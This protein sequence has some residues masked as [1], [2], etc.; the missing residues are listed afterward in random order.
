MDL[1]GRDLILGVDL[2]QSDCHISYYDVSRQDTVTVTDTSGSPFFPN[3]IFWE[4]DTRKWYSGGEAL[5]IKSKNQ[6]M[7]IEPLKGRPGS[8]ISIGEE[9][10]SEK[11]LLYMM[12]RLNVE[13]AMNQLKTTDILSICITTDIEH[14]LVPEFETDLAAELGISK[15]KVRLVHRANSYLPYILKD[16]VD[17]RYP[18]GIFNFSK[19]G[20]FY[21]QVQIKRDKRPIQVR[22]LF[23]SFEKELGKDS[24]TLPK[25]ELDAIFTTIVKRI[26]KQYTLSVFYLTGIGFEGQWLK[27]SKKILCNHK[28]VFME[29]NLFAKG[30]CYQAYKELEGSSVDNAVIIAE[31]LITYDIGLRGFQKGEEAYIPIV[32]AGAEWF[33]SAGS[34][35][36]FVDQARSIELVY[37]NLI[38]DQVEKELIPI[39]P[40]WIKEDRASKIQVDISFVSDKKGLITIKHKGFGL[41]NPDT[42]MVYKKELTLE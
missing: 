35:Q 19:E 17:E 26:V 30:A 6:G 21:R 5:T 16:T 33:H 13:Q 1:H 29:E 36:F 37:H 39:H 25:D 2:S 11:K 20:L 14:L 24:Y 23:H 38:N 15:D 31:G 8:R 41:M 40:Y 12:L 27:N 22:T 34:R 28:R 7:L 3:I 10:Y 32:N 18:V 9:V 4:K 42:H